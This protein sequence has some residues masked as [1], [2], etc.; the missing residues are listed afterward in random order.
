MQVDR[1]LYCTPR[2]YLVRLEGSFMLLP[3]D[4]LNCVM[5]LGQSDMNGKQV[6]GSGFFV[7]VLADD[8]VGYLYLV[9]ASHCVWDYRMDEGRAGLFARINT[10]DGPKE[11]ALPDGEH[12]FR[13]LD[14]PRTVDIA[15]HLWPREDR[16]HLLEAG[17][18]WVPPSMFFDE[19]ALSDDVNAGV[20]IGDEVVALGLFSYHGGKARNEVMV[21]TGN[22]A[23]VPTE[24]VATAREL[25]P[26]RLYL[27]ELRSLKG[28]SG[29]PV[30]VRHRT[31][32]GSGSST[33]SLLGVMLGHYPTGLAEEF[34]GV[35]PI[36][37][38]VHAGIGM[39][40]P[41]DELA[42][43]LAQENVVAERQRLQHKRPSVA[44]FDSD[45]S[46]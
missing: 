46:G 16:A 7:R 34:T 11:V 24:P 13:N 36:E 41:A 28:L 3:Q 8:D 38:S 43:I 15:V 27:T 17:Y 25:G 12:W 4:L 20:G 21:R 14:S 29:S 5:F 45:A 26:M 33:V 40:A 2:R 18:R 39:V 19:S 10:V 35:E 23:L 42:Q 9:T 37:E 1:R 6:K 30:F 31:M 44:R 22:L 32:I